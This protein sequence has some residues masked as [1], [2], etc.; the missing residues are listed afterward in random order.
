MSSIASSPQSLS[1]AITAR[2]QRLR[3]V[4]LHLPWLLGSML[5]LLWSLG[6]LW[7]DFPVASLRLVAVGVFV[8]LV[9]LLAIRV[10]PL[11][12]CLAWLTALWLLVLGSWLILQPR[13]DRAWQPDVAELPW[14]EINGD[15][16]TLHNVRHTEY[17]SLTDFTPHWQSRRFR[18][19]QLQGIDVFINYWGSPWMS[20][21][22]LSF[23]FTDGPPLCFSIETRKETGEGY[24]A[25][26]GLYRQY[27]LICLAADER[28]V[29]RLRT[30]YRSGEESFLYRT[31][32]R[33]ERVREAFLDYLKM[34][35]Q[36]HEQP[37]WYH[38]ITANCTTAMRGQRPAKKRSPWDWRLLINGKVD[39]LLYDLGLIETAGLDFVTLRS[40]AKINQAAQQAGDDADFYRA[41]RQQRPGF[42]RS[43]AD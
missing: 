22:I 21:P 29:I 23:Q 18:L 6:A 20:H 43:S 3:F 36:I 4:F 15:E 40:R 25:I 13:H 26:G 32:V 38:A 41:I 28:D 31:K 17:R 7:Y 33:P 42:E 14:A 9:A 10:R 37:R 19:S 30:I 27:E 35:N 5:G 8:L 34:I 24:S 11:S 16:V 2:V 1:L 12:Y 39:R